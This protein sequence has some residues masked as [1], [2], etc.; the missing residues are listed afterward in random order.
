[1]T[2]AAQN[3]WENHWQQ[4]WFYVKFVCVCLSEDNAYQ[5][6]VDCTND[7]DF[8][9]EEIGNGRFQT[10]FPVAKYVTF[11]PWFVPSYKYIFFLI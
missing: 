1:M 11:F 3:N 5:D 9:V 2:D 7:A 8:T 4:N 6:E 10:S